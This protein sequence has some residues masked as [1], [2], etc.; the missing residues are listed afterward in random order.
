MAKSSVC[1]MFYVNNMR[2]YIECSVR[3]YLSRMKHIDVLWRSVV[4]P[5]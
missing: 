4:S 3:K 5:C 2:R 1:S